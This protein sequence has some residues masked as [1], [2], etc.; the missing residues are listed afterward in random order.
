MSEYS[1]AEA[2]SAM[3]RMA[4]H[5]AAN[6]WGSGQPAAPAVAPPSAAAA[7]SVASA[8][9]FLQQP[10]PGAGSGI[11]T[12]AAAA[13]SRPPV[14]AS[15]GGRGGASALAGHAA[16]A[17]LADPPSVNG[18]AGD[19]DD[20]DGEL[21]A[22]VARAFTL[23]SCQRGDCQ[24]GPAAGPPA[25]PQAE[26]VG[27]MLPSSWWCT[28]RPRRG[29]RGAVGGQWAQTLLT[30]LPA[31][32]RQPASAWACV[33]ADDCMSFDYVY[34]DDSDE[35]ADA[36]S[37]SSQE[38]VTGAPCTAGYPP[39]AAGLWQRLHPASSTEGWSTADV[40]HAYLAPAGA[41]AAAGQRAGSAAG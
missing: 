40:L 17:P 30:W 15:S 9:L 18:G 37:D 33:P 1:L 32:G 5:H 29:G 22:A 11:S 38:Q 31:P 8:A 4:A 13:G 35:L 23:G 7:S 14:Q 25:A 10:A 3:S 6:G 41:A 24:R 2:Q 27:A 26:C 39:S 21:L 12:G 16:A 34:S 20:D 19:D 28:C 36:G